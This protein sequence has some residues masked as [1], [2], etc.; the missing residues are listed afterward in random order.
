MDPRGPVR[1]VLFDQ[2][3]F[4]HGS[5]LVRGYISDEQYLQS[6]AI[7]YLKHMWYL[8]EY[9]SFARGVSRAYKLW[10]DL[11]L[12]GQSLDQK[13]LLQH[14]IDEAFAIFIAKILLD[15]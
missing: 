13:I 3:Q 9:F 15:P 4:V 14:C 1:P 6:V 8:I 5:R 2:F 10:G 11:Q 12:H 7:L